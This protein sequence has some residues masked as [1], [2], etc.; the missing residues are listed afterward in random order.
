MRIRSHASPEHSQEHLGTASIPFLTC[1]WTFKLCAGR[2][3]EELAEELSALQAEAVELERLIQAE[4]ELSAERIKA[5]TEETEEVEPV[6][7]NEGEEV[8]QEAEVA[9][10]IAGEESD[11]DV[12][13]EL[14]A[15]EA[16]IEEVEE[17]ESST[18][19]DT[20]GVEE[21]DTA[22]EQPKTE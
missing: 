20:S 19:E 6:V 9:E 10:V 8:P 18:N 1:C 15:E 4:Q 3:E 22:D 14:P 13:E 5:R 11:A 7:E 21:S 17:D 16:E 2:T 12:A